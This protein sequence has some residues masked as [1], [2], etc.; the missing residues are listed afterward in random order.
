MNVWERA[1]LALYIFVTGLAAL[2]FLTVAAG[3]QLALNYLQLVL[4]WPDYRLILGVASGI[5]FLVAARFLWAGLAILRPR[6]DSDQALI[7]TTDL[8][9]VRLTMPALESMVVRAARQIKGIREVK[10]RLKVL[11]G[12]LAVMLELTVLPDRSLPPLAQEAQEAVRRYLSEIAGL[13]VLE[14]RVLVSGLTPESIRR[15]E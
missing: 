5:V 6:S 11:P 8:G 12:G 4:S 9:E 10:V 7:Q 15:V 1:L 13:E 3:W 14:V 2:F